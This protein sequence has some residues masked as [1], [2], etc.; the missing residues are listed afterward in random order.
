MVYAWDMKGSTCKPSFTP[1]VKELNGLELPK[2]TVLEVE[3]VPELQGEVCM[4][5]LVL[6]T[7]KV[8]YSIVAYPS[9]LVESQMYL[10]CPDRLSVLNCANH[11]LLP[12]FFLLVSETSNLVSTLLSLRTSSSDGH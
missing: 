6:I 10:F 1:K 3:F 11:T 4:M 7:I 9:S 12:S 2:G 8:S 5:T